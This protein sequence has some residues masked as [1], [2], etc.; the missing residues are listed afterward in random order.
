MF[1]ITLLGGTPTPRAELKYR[2]AYMIEK[3]IHHD[4]WALM[5]LLC[6]WPSLHS[7][8]PFLLF[9]V[10]CSNIL[11]WVG[12]WVGGWVSEEWHLLVIEIQNSISNPKC[13]KMRPKCP[14]PL[15]HEL[16]CWAS[17][18]AFLNSIYLWLPLSLCSRVSVTLWKK[19]LS[20][21]IRPTT[22]EYILQ[23]YVTSHREA[24]WRWASVTIFCCNTLK[25][26]T[27]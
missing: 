2:D 4:L 7:L 1:N 26:G 21:S 27:V 18:S 23:P 11:I 13:L 16:L 22:A 5:Y 9:C 6:K 25:V 3:R 10:H 14:A 17:T 15:H 20:L 24:Y 19:V 8:R 12:G